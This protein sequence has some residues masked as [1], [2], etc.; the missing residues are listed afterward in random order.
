MM[1]YEKSSAQDNFRKFIYQLQPKTK[2][3]QPKA[4]TTCQETWKDPHKIIQT[5]YDFIIKSN[6]LKWRT[7]VC[8]FLYN[9][10]NANKKKKFGNVFA[11]KYT[12]LYN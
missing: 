4:K 1:A 11:S 10:R 8:V 3:L 5:K 2:T 12:H 9:E 6:M 7:A